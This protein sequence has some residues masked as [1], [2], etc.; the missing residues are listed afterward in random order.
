MATACVGGLH[1]LER[2]G[3][4]TS[5]PHG[6]REWF[7]GR[8]SGVLLLPTGLWFLYFIS[9]HLND[10]IEQIAWLLQDWTIALPLA[11]SVVTQ[12]IHSYLGMKEIIL[13]Y[14]RNRNLFLICMLLLQTIVV[15]GSGFFTV[16]L[17]RKVLGT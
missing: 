16:I 5:V 17:L 1:L 2:N 14:V 13:D 8:F 6:S 3:A 7:W 15:I 10:E 12:A 11:I 9:N 4:V